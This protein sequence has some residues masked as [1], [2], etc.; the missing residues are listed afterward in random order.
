M[1][2][3]V[4]GLLTLSL[5]AIISINNI[6]AVSDE[7]SSKETNACTLVSD[8]ESNIPN[9]NNIVNKKYDSEGN[10]ESFDVIVPLAE[11]EEPE[12]ETRGIITVIVTIYKTCKIASTMGAGFNPCTYLALALGR[13]IINGSPKWDPADYGDW[14]VVRTSHFGYKPGCEPRHSQGCNGWYYTYSY[15]KIK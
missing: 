10:L 6:Y 4:I 3:L 13:A 5:I 7:S 9:E 12:A 1:K 2:K 8:E 11:G 15:A 14:R